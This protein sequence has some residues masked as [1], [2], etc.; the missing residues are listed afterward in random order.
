MKDFDLEN[1]Q[2]EG[3]ELKI[4]T[5]PDPVLSEIAKPVAEDE[6]NDELKLYLENNRYTSLFSTDTMYYTEKQQKLNLSDTNFVN[7]GYYVLSLDAFINDAD[8]R[9]STFLNI[10]KNHFKQETEMKSQR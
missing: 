1:Y 2:L 4:Y 7:V 6:F 9:N 5:Y 8:S 3:K 10:L